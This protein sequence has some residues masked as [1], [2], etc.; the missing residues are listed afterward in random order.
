MFIYAKPQQITAL[1]AVTI[2]ISSPAKQTNPITAPDPNIRVG[3]NRQIKRDDNKKEIDINGKTSE[4]DGRILE[5]YCCV[6][7]AG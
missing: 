7:G 1:I 6:G 3:K 2:P 5:Y 4:E